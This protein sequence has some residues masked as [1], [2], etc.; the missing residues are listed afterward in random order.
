[1]Y[2]DSQLEFSD[3]QAVT[4]TAISTNVVD[5][6]VTSGAA[7]SA[8]GTYTVT[9]SSLDLGQD[10]VP[11]YLVVQTVAA[12]TDTS[13][14]ATLTITLES[15]DNVG[16]S[17]PTVHFTTGALAFAAF[18]PANTR[19]VTIALPHGLYE[20]YVGVRYTVASGPLT[21]GTFD[22]Y[23]TTDPAGVRRTYRSG[24]AVS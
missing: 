7:A 24:F 15:D 11:L 9:N 14:D 16:L 18:S 10:N 5:I 3:A 12:A 22:A 2:I 19:L 17:S 23:L 1:M 21:A 8:Q 4:S 13:S 6:L 20:R